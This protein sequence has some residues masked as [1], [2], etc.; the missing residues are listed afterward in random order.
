MIGVIIRILL[1]RHGSNKELFYKK[2]GLEI[3][4]V[5]FHSIMYQDLD[6]FFQREPSARSTDLLGVFSSGR[7]RFA[8]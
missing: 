5:P 6:Y 8:T 2:K 3:I 7:V 1:A 4:Q